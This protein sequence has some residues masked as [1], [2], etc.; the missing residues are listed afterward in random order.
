MLSTILEAQSAAHNLEKSVPDVN[1]VNVTKVVKLE[2]ADGGWEAE[3]EVWKPN[4]TIRML[5]IQTQRPVLD[6]EYYLVRM[7]NLLNIIAYELE[8]SMREDR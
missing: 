5:N 8:E 1:Q 4:Q 2:T 7:D 3:A 6:Q